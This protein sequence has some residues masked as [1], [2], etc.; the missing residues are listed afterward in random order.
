MKATVTIEFNDSYEL[1]SFITGI[2]MPEPAKDLTHQKEPQPDP[3]PTL[4]P[5]PKPA[6]KTTLKKSSKR[7]RKTSFIPLQPIAGETRPVSA[8]CGHIITD[9]PVLG[10]C[11]K[12][13]YNA[14]YKA[15]KI[16]EYKLKKATGKS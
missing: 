8:K 1:I 16:E 14:G 3:E 2:K 4:P 13:C 11:S 6:A 5:N 15:K 9:K 10:Y 12:S 7:G